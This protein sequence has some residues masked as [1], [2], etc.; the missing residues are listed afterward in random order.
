[1]KNTN[2]QSNQ[3]SYPLRIMAGI[4]LIYLAYSL[5]KTWA[6]LDNKLLFG[7]FI[8]IFGVIGILLLITSAL[9]LLRNRNAGASGIN[10]TDSSM[11]ESGEA[12]QERTNL[13]EEDQEEIQEE[14]QEENQ[15]KNP[16][17]IAD[18]KTDNGYKVE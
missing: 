17:E 4:Y 10:M 6:D 15:E 12:S 8:G 18:K 13:A 14:I 9:G 3:V 16:E 2:K 5:V 1:M 7:V 11:E